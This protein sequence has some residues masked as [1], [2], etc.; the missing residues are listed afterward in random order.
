MKYQRESFKHKYENARHWVVISAFGS[1]AAFPTATLAVVELSLSQ[2]VCGF[3]CQSS[4][5]STGASIFNVNFYSEG[6]YLK[7]FLYLK[8][9]SEGFV[10][11]P[12]L[13]TSTFEY[14]LYLFF[15][16]FKRLCFG[17]AEWLS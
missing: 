1:L 14:F 3:H 8:F 9:I 11:F 13:L 17:Q 12:Q 16:C 5:R 4:G 6:L 7:D 15:G 2:S 10:P